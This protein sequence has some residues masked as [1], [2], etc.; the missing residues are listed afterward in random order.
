MGGEDAPQF[1][2][3]WIVQILTPCHRRKRHITP[4]CAGTLISKK[5]VAA[6]HHCF[7]IEVI[8]KIFNKV[9]NLQNMIK[10]VD[11][12]KNLH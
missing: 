1:A 4:E 9:N 10:V 5:F 6:S 7:Y 2:F 12:T 8:D 3:P 11:I